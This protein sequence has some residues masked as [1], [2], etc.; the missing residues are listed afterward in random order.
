MRNAGALG[1]TV[2]YPAGT[3]IRKHAAHQGIDGRMNIMLGCRGTDPV[4]VGYC[5]AALRRMAA[6]DSQLT[7]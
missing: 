3:G 5:H 7:A 6:T 2:E 4:D 1:H